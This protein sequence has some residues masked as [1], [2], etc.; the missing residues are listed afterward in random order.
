ML[1][2]WGSWGGTL[3]SGS[4]EEEAVGGSA[5]GSSQFM[6]RLSVTC[7]TRSAPLC[8]HEHHRELTVAR[9][10]AGGGGGAGGRPPPPPAREVPEALELKGTYGTTS[11]S[12]LL[13]FAKFASSNASQGAKPGQRGP[14]CAVLLILISGGRREGHVP[15]KSFGFI[16]GA[17]AYA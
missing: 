8:R 10:G 16:S 11:I 17:S 13:S 9:F 5:G 1:G 4:E 12:H 14:E 15:T 6:L 2:D 3:E 7:V